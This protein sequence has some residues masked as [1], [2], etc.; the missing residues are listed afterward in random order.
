MLLDLVVAELLP[1]LQPDQHGA[2]LVGG[3]QDDRRAAS[4]RR[5]D[6]RQ[7][8]LRTSDPSRLERVEATVRLAVM[9]LCVDGTSS[10]RSGRTATSSRP[11]AARRRR[12][13]S[14]RARTRRAPPRAGAWARLRAILDHARPL[15]PP[16]RRRRPRRGAPA[17]RSTCRAGERACSSSR[18]ELRLRASRS[19]R[20]TPDVLLDGGETLELAGI[21][22][23]TLNVP[24]HSPGHLA[25]AADGALFSGDVLFAGSVGRTD[26]PGADW[27]TLLASIRSLVE[28]FPPE[29]IVYP[30][31][32]PATTLGAELERNPFLASSARS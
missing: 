24:G 11:D 27:D 31:H 9:S 29:T 28:R 2:R 30:G 7:L 26:L 21:S 13:S 19:S 10:A 5:L 1:G 15:G 23:E 4:V 16:R 25:Y 6:L 20:T 32:G 18:D 22:F 8:Q 12:S 3:M 17:R 14:I